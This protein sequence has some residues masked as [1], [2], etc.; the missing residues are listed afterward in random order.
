MK[1]VIVESPSKAKTINKYLGAGYE[2]TASFGHIRDLPSKNGSVNPEDGFAMT[3]DVDEKSERHIK[4]IAKLASKADEILLATDPD[5]EGEAISWHVLEVLKERGILKNQP[6]K[7]IV[8]NEITKSAVLKAVS[9]PRELDQSLIEA[10]L[11]RRALDYLVGFTLSPVL[12]RKLPG[13]RSAGRVQSVAL[14]LICDREGEIERFKPQEYWSINAQCATNSKEP[15][16]AKLSLLAG[17]K[18]EKFT[19]STE[20]QATSAV[21]AIEAHTPYRVASVEKKKVQRHP[22][23]PFTTSTLQQEAS[24]KLG[25]GASRTMQLAQR[26]YEGI[27]LN[28]EVTGLI[29]YMR[30]DSVNISADAIGA[31]RETILGQF[32]KD[33]LPDAPR[34]YKTKS[35]NAQEAH[36]GIRPTSLDR[37]PE[38]LEG[39]LESDQW[40]LYQL[41]WR[42]MMASQMTSA[43]FDQVSA[44]I[45]SPDQSVALRAVGTTRVFDG[46]LKLYEE[47]QDDADED[48]DSRKLPPLTEGDAITILQVDPNQHFTQPPPR[49]SE[50]SLVKKMEELGIGRPS[51]Y[52]TILHV[53]Q[54]RQYVHLD[55]KTFI[56]DE[57]GRLVTTFLTNFFGQYVEFSFTADLED[58]LDDI[59]SGNRQ[60]KNVLEVFWKGFHEATEGA[61]KLK[62]SD[63]IDVLNDQL[64]SH[65][66]PA[67]E[68]GTPSRQC[69]K[70]T[71]G[72]LSLKLG[73]F[74]AF[75]GCSNYPTC[76][77]TRRLDDTL[78]LGSD[79]AANADGTEYPR[80]LGLDTTSNLEITVRSGPYGYYLQWGDVGTDK[81]V[82]P[83]RVPVP[84]TSNPA[85]ITFD[86]AKVLGNLPRLLGK[87]PDTGE[88]MTAGIGRFGPYIKHQSTFASLKKEDDVLTISLDRALELLVEAANKPK[89]PRSF[90]ARKK[91]AAKAGPKTPTKKKSS[92]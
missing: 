62:I 79:D 65:F 3:W 7:R 26:L 42:R 64:G 21:A 23:P 86:E 70:C 58:Q 20:A 44:D 6:V 53:L 24:R 71:D 25:F 18:V 27:E 45:A 35:K 43:V 12:W 22:A 91:P 92:S 13:S 75:V 66:F 5:R 2:V 57:R 15:F 34:A 83:K 8:F 76:T 67:G 11:A 33:Y 87:N 74:G 30:T 29:T 60:W 63:V 46:F 52:A 16:G 9:N 72:Q 55:K 47:G 40:R 32:G 50:A 68:D 17:K 49:Y 36:E 56:P 51:T 39:K 69:P 4:D 54:D 78:E 31:C 81:K 10:Y 80:A 84:K 41:I 59:S 37:L 14:R 88:E 1:V 28:G 90:G 19:I 48:D 82:K 38:Q 85:T 89:S 61:S 73:K 77:H